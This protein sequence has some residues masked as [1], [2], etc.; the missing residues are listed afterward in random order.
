M[1]VDVTHLIAFG[2]VL[3][4]LGYRIFRWRLDKRYV[5]RPKTDRG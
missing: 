5:R 4:P 2:G 1:S 3:M